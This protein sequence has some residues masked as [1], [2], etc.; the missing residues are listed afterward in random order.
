MSPPR[1]AGQTD[2][3]PRLSEALAEFERDPALDSARGFDTLAYL[4]LSLSK[5]QAERRGKGFDRFSP[6]GFGF[7]N[8]ARKR[9][10]ETGV[11]GVR[12]QIPRAFGPPFGCFASLRSEI[13]I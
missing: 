7:G 11:F 6:N 9:G 10:S 2:Q 3:G 12:A 1:S 8:G 13:A 4:V 5:D